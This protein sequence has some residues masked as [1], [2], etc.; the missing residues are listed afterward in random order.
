MTI[1]DCR[2]RVHLILDHEQADRVPIDLWASTGTRRKGEA[3]TGVPFS[4]YLDSHDV[5][6][7][8]IEGPRYIGPPLFPPTVLSDGIQGLNSR[9][10]LPEYWGQHKTLDRPVHTPFAEYH[11]YGIRSR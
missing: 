6:L 10:P 8:Y 7:R 5:D 9:S 2:E 3:V 11:L 4:A 1:V